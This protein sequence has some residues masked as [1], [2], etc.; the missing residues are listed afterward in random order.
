MEISPLAHKLQLKSGQRV[1]LLNAP[2]GY[3][4][5]LE[6]LPDGASLAQ[7]LAA[8]PFDAVQLFARTSDELGRL[9][10]AALAA[11]AP[12]GM[13]WIAYPKKSAGLDSDL[14][15]D[16]GWAPIIGA[17]WQPVRQVAMDDTWS[18]LR[19][20]PVEHASAADA[21]AAQY[22]GGKAHLRPIYDKLL[23]VARRLDP[24]VAVNVRQS[25]VALARGQQFANIVPS[26]RD[27]VDLA[28]KLPGVAAHGRLEES[29]GVGSGAMTHRIALTAVEQVDEEVAAWLGQAHAALSQAA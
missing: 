15:R 18:A 28:L 13:L 24:A 16:A 2:A 5:L 12:G 25:Y 27:R 7:D 23:E 6:P 21:V 3:R 8:A 4:E 9:A 29:G 22:S 19:F 17:G 26:T 11:L 14:T 10:P 20:K 1:A